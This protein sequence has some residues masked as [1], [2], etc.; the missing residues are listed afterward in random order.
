[1]E[2]D[3][4]DLWRNNVYLELGWQYYEQLIITFNENF[5]DPVSTEQN[6]TKQQTIGY[7]KGTKHYLQLH[8]NRLGTVDNVIR[9][10]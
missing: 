6:R 5:I 1:M 4:G 7:K 9:R 8:L 10:L 3:L 2:R